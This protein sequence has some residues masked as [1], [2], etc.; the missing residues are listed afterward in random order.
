[1]I[2]MNV[3]DKKD[4]KIETYPY[5]GKPIPVKDVCIRWLSQAGPKDS[6][7]YGLRFF[8]IGPSGEIPIRPASSSSRM[9]RSDR[10]MREHPTGAEPK[11]PPTT[12][13]RSW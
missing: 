1:M 4:Q 2:V 12:F 5:K 8:T 13:S 9:V 10:I 3:S 7:E 6:V 11:V